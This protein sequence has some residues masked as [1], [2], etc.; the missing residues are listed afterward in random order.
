V[1]LAAAPVDGAANE[2]LIEFLAGVFDCRRSD[3][4]ITAGQKSRD[5]RV[6]IAGMTQDELA[7]HVTRLTS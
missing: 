1:R 5:K 6:R 3:I 4:S 7:R 2:A